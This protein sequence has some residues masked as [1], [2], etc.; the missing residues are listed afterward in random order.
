MEEFLKDDPLKKPKKIAFGFIVVVLSV[1][2]IGVFAAFH[3]LYV[4]YL[5]YRANEKDARRQLEEIRMRSTKAEDAAKVRLEEIEKR[6][7]AFVDEALQR[8]KLAED[9]SNERIKAAGASAKERIEGLDAEYASKQKSLQ[10]DFDSKRKV[11][12]IE[13]DAK[14]QD[15]AILLRGFKERFDAQTNDFEKAILAKRQELARFQDLRDQC[16]DLLSQYAAISNGMVT[17]RNQR[18]E[19][20]KKERDAQ[21]AYNVLNGK[22][23]AGKSE[24]DQVNMEKTKISADVES[25]KSELAKL[26]EAIRMKTVEVGVLDKKLDSSKDEFAKVE[27]DLKSVSAELLKVRSEIT[28]AKTERESAVKERED[29]VKRCGAAEVEKANVEK[30]LYILRQRKS[31]LNVAVKEVENQLKEKKAELEKANTGIGGSDK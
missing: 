12:A 23:G 28:S 31:E 3:W 26:K 29:I 18:D 19:A 16:A 13:L 4:D 9:T 21:D 11:L 17:A 22:I 30:D 5:S 20:L 25:L 2:M 7:K 1:M 15:I 8:A 24:L 14:K 10:E 6:S 27:G